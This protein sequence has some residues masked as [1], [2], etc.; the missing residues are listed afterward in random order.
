M[1]AQRKAI[2]IVR[3]SEVKGREGPS[4]ASPT[5]Q[6]GRLE[7]AAKRDGLELAEV[8]EAMDLSATK[9]LDKRTDLLRALELIEDGAAHVVVAAYFDRLFRSLRVQWEFVSRVEAA[10]GQVLAVDVGEVTGKTASQWLSSSMLGLVAE[11]HGR[12][13]AERT[14]DAQQAAI[15]R[16][17]VP[18]PNIPPGLVRGEDGVCV[19][20][21]DRDIV[22]QAFERR[23]EVASVEEVRVFLKEHGIDRSYHG[24]GAMLKSR[25]YLGEIHFGD[26]E[27]NLN[28]HEAIVPL[29]LWQRVQRIRVP[30]GR[31][32]KSD[33]LLA[34]LGV[35]RC[36][37]CDARMVV[38]TSHNSTYWLYRCPPTGDC[39][40]RVTISADIA[41]NVVVEEVKRV[42]ADAEGRASVE[43]NARDAEVALERAQANL[44]A[45]IR[46]F[47]VVEDEA[48]AKERLAELRQVRDR[49]VE[50]LEHLGG[51][52]AVVT[53]NA[54]DDWDRLS[55]DARRALIRATV[56]RARVSPGRGADR[57][58]V[59]LFGE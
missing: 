25:L 54:A 8:I 16:G 36:A 59:E 45:G 23:G 19:P 38:G 53:I 29:D 35:L 41:E 27:P 18:W 39:E 6:L 21:D 1:S 20:D 50:R 47:T 14:R 55:L 7:D 15:D 57:V 3:V 17:V 58:A 32:A 48:A 49:A 28:A 40:R 2:G 37:S 56:A 26:Y 22:L 5:E 9:P 12:A 34:R 43:S 24:V 10:G 4:F 46:A 11:Y 30:R 31:R 52:R 13:T 44:D 42:L 33:R 51:H